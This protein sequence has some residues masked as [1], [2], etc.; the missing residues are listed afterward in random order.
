[1]GT[2]LNQYI[3]NTKIK[4]KTMIQKSYLD[5]ITNSAITEKFSTLYPLLNQYLLHS[6]DIQESRNG[7][8]KEVMDFKTEITSPYHRCVGSSKRDINVFFLLAEA[9]WIWA[10]RKDVKFLNIFNSN[11]SNYSDN[12]EVFHAPYG[13]RLRH[14]GVSSTDRQP[15]NDNEALHYLQGEDQ[16]EKAI[17]ILTN[18][19]ETRRCVLSIWNPDLDLSTKSKDLPCNDLVMFKIRKGK[20]YTTISNRSNDLHWGL[21]TNIF[22]F[23]ILSELISG[24]LGIELYKQTHN[25]QSLHFYLDNPIAKMMNK[26]FK[27]DNP[28]LYDE[29][30]PSKIDFNFPTELSNIGRLHYLDSI[31][32]ILLSSLEELYDEKI[33]IDH[34][35]EVKKKIKNFSKY[36]FEV[37]ELLEM[38]VLYKIS[39]D[40]EQVRISFIEHIDSHYNVKSLCKDY[41]LLALNW[42]YNRLKDKRTVEITCSKQ[43]GNY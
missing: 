13:F 33:N 26:E 1:M 36:L 30:E 24:I 7:N 21:P 2:L 23:S 20:L 16:I 34:M 28:D 8:T 3:I 17:E 35:I 27:I 39:S 14:H 42:F 19:P 43:I 18:D 40:K 6:E 12:G 41:K 15:N 11:M 31:I 4:Y 10:G 22:Q 38:Y 37:F 5:Y 29:C 32:N 9:L 25:S